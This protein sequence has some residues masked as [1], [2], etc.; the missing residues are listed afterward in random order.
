MEKAD[1][2]VNNATIVTMN[3]ENQILEDH[4]LVVKRSVIAAIEPS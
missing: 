2:I 4:S 1:L 3:K